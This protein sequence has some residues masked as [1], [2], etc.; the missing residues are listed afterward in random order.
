MFPNTWATF[1]WCSYSS[2]F[3]DK[4][5]SGRSI[6]VILQRKNDMVYS[7]YAEYT[8]PSCFTGSYWCLRQW[9][10]FIWKSSLAFIS[11]KGFTS[12]TDFSCHVQFPLPWKPFFLIFCRYRTPLYTHHR[13]LDFTAFLFVTS[14]PINLIQ[15]TSCFSY[16]SVQFLPHFSYLC[17]SSICH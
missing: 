7:T 11:T 6:S 3:L 14:S 5:R 17:V 13:Q 10:L 8:F 15:L 4:T 16:F 2:L 1:W 12:P 9:A